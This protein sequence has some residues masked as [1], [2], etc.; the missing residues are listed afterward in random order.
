[1]IG[2]K[3]LSG[4]ELEKCNERENKR[5]GGMGSNLESDLLVLCLGMV[6]L[7]CA[8]QVNTFTII[9]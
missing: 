6:V 7:S 5:K 9:S 3:F 8:M 2:L 1:M 4:K